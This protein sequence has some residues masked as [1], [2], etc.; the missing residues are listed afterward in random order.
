[1]KQQ[2][3]SSVLV[4]V[5]IHE[6]DPR[7]L[8]S[9]PAFLK[10]CKGHY[11]I[12]LMQVS[13]KPLVDAQNMIADYFLSQTNHRFL[14]MLENDHYGHT[15]NM[16]KAL[17]RSNAL[18]CGMN[19]HSRH[20]PYVSCLMR[21]LPD[22][23]QTERFA[24]INRTSGYQDVDLVGFGMTLI[25]REVFDKLSKPFFRLNEFRGPDSYATDISFNDD[26]KKAGIKPVGCF[27]YT[28]PHRDITKENADEKRLEGMEQLRNRR[29]I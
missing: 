9:L 5:P 11:D 1:M 19:Y 8:D 2:V 27:E 25:R 10:E 16:L 26:L 14:L 3:R 23:P 24:G 29:P 20:Y 22:R 28:L 13:N 18:V 7:F 12:E 21:E 15:R 6:P 17:L 4:G